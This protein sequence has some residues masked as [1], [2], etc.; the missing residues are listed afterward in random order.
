MQWLMC[1]VP[2]MWGAELVGLL[3][4]RSLR[5]A[6][7]TISKFKKEEFYVCM[8]EGRK[9]YVQKEHCFCR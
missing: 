6:W 3:E 5:P 9:C 7:A 4:A 2:A 8:F 1:V